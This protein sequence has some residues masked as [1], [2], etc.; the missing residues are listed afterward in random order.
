MDLKKKN[1]TKPPL[2]L[3]R[4]SFSG[5]FFHVWE[6]RQDTK[7][8]KRENGRLKMIGF[9]EKKI[10]L[11]MKSGKAAGFLNSEAHQLRQGKNLN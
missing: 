1:T 6:R 4:V 5:F 7:K 8:K 9:Q 3:F 10:F 2:Q 11:A